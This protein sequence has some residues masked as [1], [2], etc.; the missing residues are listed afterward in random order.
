[1]ESRHRRWG[2]A[3]RWAGWWLFYLAAAALALA[4]LLPVAATHLPHFPADP[5]LQ[6]GVWLPW[7]TAQRLAAW[8]DPY[9]APGLGWPEGLDLRPHVWNLGCPLLAA[10][11]FLVL[12]PVLAFNLSILGFASLNGLAGHLLG[13]RVAGGGAGSLPAVTAGLL[14]TLSPAPLHELCSGRPEQGFLAPLLL[15]ASFLAAWA[16]DPGRRSHAVGLGVALASSGLCY[17]LA[18]VLLGACA[19]VPVVSYVIWDRP[20]IRVRSLMW[21]MVVAGLV[22]LPGILPLLGVLERAHEAAPGAAEYPSLAVAGLLR[23]LAPRS[24]A[25]PDTV[26]PLG[27]SL[28]LL[29]ALGHPRRALVWLGVGGTALA[30]AL[31]PQVTWNG[32]GPGFPGPFA[33]FSHL[34]ILERFWWPVRLLGLATVGAV[35]ASAVG[36]ASRTGRASPWTWA[37]ALVGLVVLEGVEMAP[38]G[39]TA[40]FGGAVHLVKQPALWREL[41]EGGGPWPILQVPLLTLPNDEVLDQVF[42]R[43][44]LFG[45]LAQNHP[46][47]VA[48]SLAERASEEPFCH[49]ALEGCEGG[50]TSEPSALRSALVARGIGVVVARLDVPTVP[51]D[52]V[53]EWATA[54]LGP[55]DTAEGP[56]LL[57][58]WRRDLSGQERP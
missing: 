48:R 7:H 9:T 5:D 30:L 13:W 58:D 17:W 33:L 53:L 25:R 16:A 56:W 47:L 35:G 42:H 44:P 15:A 43:Q 34:P 45:G 24:L 46:R 37:V 41:G 31:G 39:R 50:G 29:L 14:A 49:L 57:W 3:L 20:G 21:A 51:R 12:P 52:G 22:A 28:A 1:M 36:V 26:F 27:L 4:P 32:Q 11:L 40:P 54:R 10:P 38:R 23:F 19:L 2:A 18:P 6:V 8:A 55:P